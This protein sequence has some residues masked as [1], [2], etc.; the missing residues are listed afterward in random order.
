ME[1]NSSQAA[2]TEPANYGKH[3][4]AIFCT[5]SKDIKMQSTPWPSMSLSGNLIII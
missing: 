3:K 1:I 2:M 5:L 4:Q